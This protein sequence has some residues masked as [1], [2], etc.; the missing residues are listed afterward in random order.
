MAAKPKIPLR[1]RKYARTKLA[2]VNATI[3][4][5]EA[6]PMEEIT[7]NSLCDDIEISEATFFNYFAKKGDLLDYYM[8]LWTLEIAWKIRN[9]GQSGIAAIDTL[10]ATAAQQ[11]QQH[12]GL[13]GEV[14]ARLARLREKSAPQPI[15]RAERHRA[16]EKVIT[17]ENASEIEALNVS[18]LDALLVSA[19]QQAISKGELPSNTHVPTAMLGLVS[20]FYGIPLLLRMGNPDII[21][22]SY[23]QQLAIFWQG[24]RAASQRA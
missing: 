9:S 4:R 2:L 20:L 21:P 12:P 16:F 7:V 18:G 11:F 22:V 14:L 15:G 6:T 19:L 24:M 23:R 13:M 5:L 17:E 3:Q 8:Q 10:F 1:E